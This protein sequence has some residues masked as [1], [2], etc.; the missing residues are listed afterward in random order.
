VDDNYQVRSYQPRHG[1]PELG[2]ESIGPSR[3]LVAAVAGTAV[4]VAAGI[5]ALAVVLI[6]G[7]STPHTLGNRVAVSAKQVPAPKATVPTTSHGARTG[8][9]HV[10]TRA[11]RGT[12]TGGSSATGSLVLNAVMATS[13]AVNLPVPSRFGPLLRRTWARSAPG[14]VAMK[15][16]DVL[17][18]LAGSVFY[19]EQPAAHTWW[20]ISQFVPSARAKSAASTAAGKALLAQFNDIGVFEKAP[21]RGWAY[22]GSF[23]AGTCPG[24]LPT[25]VLTSWGL[26]TVGS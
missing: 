18:T 8:N 25:P 10:S 1:F 3:R 12:G 14:G 9:P 11:A 17:S 21:G 13:P 23:S 16:S 26:C 20:A 2:A 24:T 4:L 7:N 15:S 22:V 6:G 19:A 5:V